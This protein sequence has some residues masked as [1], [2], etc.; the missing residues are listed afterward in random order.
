MQL[1]SKF[2][3]SAIENTKTSFSFSSYFAR[4]TQIN[5]P[6]VQTTDRPKNLKYARQCVCRVTYSLSSEKK[7]L[8]VE[9][10]V[11]FMVSASGVKKK[12]TAAQHRIVIFLWHSS[13]D[14]LFRARRFDKLTSRESNFS[15]NKKIA[16]RK[17]ERNGLIPAF[18]TFLGEHFF[19]NNLISFVEKFL[20]IQN[21][22]KKK[23]LNYELGI[24]GNIFQRALEI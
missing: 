15:E 6:H 3:L 18:Q 8:H 9:K 16:P 1:I 11:R 4:F 19:C 2:F 20:T 23:I 7:I 10:N 14:E 5:H 21:V 24:F 22:N 17:K 12:K 13:L